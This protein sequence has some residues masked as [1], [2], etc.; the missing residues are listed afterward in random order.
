[1]TVL[2]WVALPHPAAVGRYAA[3]RATEILTDRASTAERITVALAGG[4]TPR[5]MHR[6]LAGPLFELVP[7]SQLVFFLGDERAVAP[8]HHGSNFRSAQETLLSKAP[9]HTGQVHR[10]RAEAQDL[11]G[12]AREYER[13]L[14]ALAGTPPWLDLVFLG[15]GTDGHTASLFPGEPEPDGW[16]AETRAPAE[17]AAERRLSLTYRAILSARYVLV[18]VTGAEKAARVEEVIREDGPLPM[19]RILHHRT[20]RTLLILDEAAAEQISRTAPKEER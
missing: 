8:D 2:D 18:M 10:P 14:K 16:F 9:V 11:E 17:T 5:H 6:A 13:T 19:Q 3:E 15:M 20:G 7:W 4:S 1:M 12:A